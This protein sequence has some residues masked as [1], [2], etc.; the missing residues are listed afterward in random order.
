MQYMPGNTEWELLATFENSGDV[1]GCTFS[2]IPSYAKRIKIKGIMHVKSGEGSRN[3]RV[4]LNG[5]V[6]GRTNYSFV[7]QSNAD[8]DAGVATA[9]QISVGL[10]NR[11][12]HFEIELDIEGGRRCGGTF[13]SWTD[14]NGSTDESQ[15]FHGVVDF[16]DTAVTSVQI[17]SDTGDPEFDVFEAVAR[18]SRYVG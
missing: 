8:S 15:Y 7:D 5:T 2:N 16:A 4:E 18:I 11:Y 6:V 12:T 14:S 3:I 9:A 17:V 13:K 1:D 10:D